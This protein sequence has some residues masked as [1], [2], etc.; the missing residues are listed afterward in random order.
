VAGD[1]LGDSNVNDDRCGLTVN[2][3]RHFI[4]RRSAIYS[5]R[6]RF[7]VVFEYL[8]DGLLFSGAPYGD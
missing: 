8:S 7:I 6:P 2:T 3:I 4:D 1:L 5:D